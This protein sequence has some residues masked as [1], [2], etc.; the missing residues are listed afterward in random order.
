[1]EKARE[2][3]LSY[4]Y[5]F[6]CLLANMKVKGKP[7]R[8]KKTTP[9]S[10]SNF[11]MK[12]HTFRQALK[13]AGSWPLRREVLAFVMFPLCSSQPCQ[14]HP[15]SVGVLQVIRDPMAFSFFNI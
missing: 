13:V 9:N 14:F 15:H 4:L 11:A 3:K 2:K 5:C 8:K 12:R 1:M 7:A 10:G 6:A